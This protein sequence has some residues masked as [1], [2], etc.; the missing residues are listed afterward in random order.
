[1]I[2]SLESL[3]KPLRKRVATHGHLG[4]DM[5]KLCGKLASA[6]YSEPD[7]RKSWYI[8]P[9]DQKYGANGFQTRAFGKRL[10]EI[11]LQEGLQTNLPA[12]EVNP[13]HGMSPAEGELS[14]RVN[15]SNMELQRI[16]IATPS[17]R[18]E[19]LEKTLQEGL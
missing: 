8:K 1:M 13:G 7:R 12:G 17:F 11:T 16:M 3:E 15:S 6:R 19:T 9:L 2:P 14:W 4:L 18:K 5:R 10:L